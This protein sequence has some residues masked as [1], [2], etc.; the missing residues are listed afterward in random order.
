MRLAVLRP[1]P[2]N[3]ATAARAEA[4]GFEV[5]RLPLFA[6]RPLAWVAPDPAA[7]DALLLTSAN[8]VRYGRVEALRGLPVLAV[9]AATAA[10]ARA[11]GFEV[12][13]TGMRDA[14]TLLGDVADYSR[15][16][17]LAGRDRI[18]LGEQVRAITVYASDPVDLA[19][20]AIAVLVGSTA[21]LHSAR[22][23][24]RFAELVDRAGLDRGRV[25]L[26]TLS[27]SV[28]Q[29]AGDGWCAIAV[30]GAPTDD[31]LLALCL[32]R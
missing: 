27:A 6:V 14:A 21:L 19:P 15:I 12:V 30:A 8:A 4:L 9:G 24:A 5:V 23:A 25:S 11:A 13:R 31:A 29:A 1:E 26:A 17:H 28:A 10:A 18:D 32:G 20:E 22:A 3:A 16:L 7:Y 2:G